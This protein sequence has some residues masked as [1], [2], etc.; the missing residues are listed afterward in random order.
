MAGKL[1]DENSN[2]YRE[3]CFHCLNEKLEVARNFAA[4][5]FNNSI[6]E[7]STFEL[8]YIE[9]RQKQSMELEDIYRSVGMI[10]MLPK[11][12]AFV[13]EYM[14]RISRE[15]HRDNDVQELLV[16]LEEVLDEMQLEAMPKSR[17]EFE[18]RAVLFYI[19]K[20]LEEF[21][22][23]KNEFVREHRREKN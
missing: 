19:L 4:R 22:K 13:A 8:D 3:T 10:Q 9:M 1:E 16:G 6:F 2:K 15:Y 20:Q 12:A 7:T 14:G 23:L 17:E 21:L 11:Q 18:A 5:N